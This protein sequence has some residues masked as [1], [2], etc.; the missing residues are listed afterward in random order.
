[1]R[2]VA[3][4]F[5]RLD[6]AQSSFIREQLSVTGDEAT[7]ILD[8]SATMEATDFGIVHRRWRLHRRGEY[9]WTELDGVWMIEKVTILSENVTSS[10][11]LG[12]RLWPKSG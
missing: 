9:S 6:S 4:Q 3:S 10:W 7:E 2:D 11:H 5:R 8:Q 12:S 1:M